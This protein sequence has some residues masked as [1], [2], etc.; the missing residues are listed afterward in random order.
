MRLSLRAS[1]LALSVMLP[2]T[3]GDIANFL[4]QAAVL[5]V[6]QRCDACRV[7]VDEIVKARSETKDRKIDYR[8]RTD[9]KG[10]RVGKTMRYRDSE[11]LA[12]DLL[13]GLCKDFP[14]YDWKE[15]EE[16]YELN[17][18][19]AAKDVERAKSPEKGGFVWNKNMKGFKNFCHEWVGENE[20]P[21]ITGIMGKES[22]KNIQKTVCRR[23][24]KRSKNKP[25]KTKK[26]KQSKKKKGCVLSTGTSCTDREL[27]YASKQRNKGMI[28]ERF[29]DERSRIERLQKTGDINDE[30]QCICG[31]QLRR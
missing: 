13:E 2:G 5:T 25:Q 31:V 26:K 14:T 23:T 12:T 21:L 7:I 16:Y 20:E 27:E 17:V 10:K 4:N 6:D 3:Q 1:L 18:E 15:E 29:S 30:Q 22:S 8:T 28:D 9:S 11:L 19:E 24:C